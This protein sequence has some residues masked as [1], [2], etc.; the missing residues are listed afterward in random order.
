M[1]GWGKSLKKYCIHCNDN[2]I[3][4]K[5][6]DENQVLCSKVSSHGTLAVT[7]N[8]NIIVNTGKH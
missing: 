7:R 4:V 8:K 6:G 1:L 2:Y 5:L 3:I